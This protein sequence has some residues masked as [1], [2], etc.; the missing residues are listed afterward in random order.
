[1]LVVFDFD[2]S[3][4]DDV[5]E[6]YFG[7]V[8]CPQLAMELAVTLYAHGDVNLYLADTVL[9]VFHERM[10][11][12]TRRQTRDAIARVPVSSQMLDAVKLAADVYGATVV[13]VSDSNEFYISSMLEHHGLQDKYNTEVKPSGRTTRAPACA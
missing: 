12:V 11:Y 3:L 13:I 6:I 1:V 9:D 4:A 7:K 5:S 10:P 2:E 8:L